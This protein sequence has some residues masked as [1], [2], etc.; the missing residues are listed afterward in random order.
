[1]FCISASHETQ[2]DSV[3]VEYIPALLFP[4]VLQVVLTVP[5]FHVVQGVLVVPVVCKAILLIGMGVSY[6]LYQ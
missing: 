5:L 1:M 6:V 2:G 3:F 4:H